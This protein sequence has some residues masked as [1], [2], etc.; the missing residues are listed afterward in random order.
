M[1]SRKRQV[2]HCSFT[3]IE[4][5]VVIAIIAIL[6]GMLL[7]A[8]TKAREAAASVSCK[9]NVKT[10]GLALQVYRNDYNDYI[11]T[12][13]GAGN[14][15][16]NSHKISWAQLLF[17][18]NYITGWKE[19]RCP[20]GKYYHSKTDP[21]GYD[22]NYGSQYTYGLIRDE[23]ATSYPGYT[24]L[25]GS[26]LRMYGFGTVNL[27]DVALS[28]V[29]LLGDSVY[30]TNGYMHCI[31]DLTN[32]TVA[33]DGRLYLV[34]RGLANAL[35]ADGHVDTIGRSGRVPFPQKRTDGIGFRCRPIASCALP[36]LNVPVLRSN[37]N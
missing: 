12:P 9:N 1:Q 32:G 28:S 23:N 14:N 11:Y 15:L 22:K 24:D 19:V 29:F 8:L 20:M 10:S 30:V 26:W 34:H 13:N 17:N 4:L 36:L 16:I 6:A 18:E 2:V 25:G 7:P 21:V 3:L 5:L 35:F 33:A 27:S 37:W 31:M